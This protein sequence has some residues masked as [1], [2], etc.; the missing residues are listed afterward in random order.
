MTLRSLLAAGVA[1]ICAAD[2][3]LASDGAASAAA[4][5]QDDV[6][7]DFR[8]LSVTPAG[9]DAA[10]VRVDQGAAAGLR[11]GDRVTFLPLAGTPVPGTVRGADPREATVEVLRRAGEIA[12]GVVGE[13]LVP[14]DRS[15]P[16]ASPRRAPTAARR[17]PGTR[18]ASR[19][20]TTRRCSR[21]SS[22]GRVRSASPRGAAAST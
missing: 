3:A 6:L 10:V 20:P 11:P 12:P 17:S 14:P 5:E 22:R 2:L 18:A 16:T 7:V 19:G 1:V 9:D 13:A 21:R 8:V 4:A 15:R